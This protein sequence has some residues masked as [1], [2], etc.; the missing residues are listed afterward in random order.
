MATVGGAGKKI[1]FPIDFHGDFNEVLHLGE[2]VGGK[3]R[4]EWQMNNFK[5]MIN[6]CKLRDLGYI[7]AD[8]TWSRRLGAC[9]WVKECLD[10]ALVSSD[11]LTMFPSVR[12]YHVATSTSDYSMLV[13]KTLRSGQRAPRR[14]KLFKFESLWLRDEQCKDVV[15]EAWER[16]R[17]MGTQH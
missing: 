16:G 10:R 11:C 12:L 14:S 13:L 15:N 3:L 7:K 6:R 1:C 9:G 5:A 2:K 4:P 17:S 8:Y